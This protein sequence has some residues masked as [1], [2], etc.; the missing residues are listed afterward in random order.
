MVVATSEATKIVMIGEIGTDADEAIAAIL[1][2]YAVRE[3][4]IELLAFVGN[5]VKSL[6]RAQNAKQIFTALGLGDVPVGMGERGFG[7]T[8]QECEED[9]RYLAVPTKIGHGR[10]LLRWTL[11][12]SDDNSV[13]LALNS[14][15]TDAVWLWMEDPGLFLRKVRRV[16]LMSGVEMD[17]DHPKLSSEG[18]LL[19]SIGKGGAANN[20][21][22]PG[23]TLH[24]FDAMQRHGI[25]TAI[26]TRFAAYGCKMPFSI[27]KAMAASGNPIGVRIDEQQ[28]VRLLE[29]WQKA[30][31][32]VDSFER[33]DLPARCDRTWFVNTFCGGHDP[34]DDNV[35]LYMAEVAWYDPMNLIASSDELRA[36]FYRPYEVD[37]R[38]IVH[39]VIGLTEENHGVIDSQGQRLFMS[40]GITEA[41]R[42]GQKPIPVF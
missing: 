5:H 16:V 42:L 40:H 36:R 18:F 28:E 21:F 20:N 17:G 22:D 29:L 33:G 31:A 37:V 27:F 13:V 41:L 38:G 32:P 30:N 35:L 8:S 15:F 23:S 4:Y 14:G 10:A 1:A 6:L 19:P 34:G 2:C 7:S 25:P 12:Q 26:T 3:R 24:L 39:E 9:P 11:E